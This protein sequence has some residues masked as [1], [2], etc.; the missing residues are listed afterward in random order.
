MRVAFATPYYL[1]ALKFGGPPQKIHAIARR[2]VEAG[3]NVNVLTFNH[4][5][6]RSA[7]RTE[8]DGV[9]VQ[10]LPWRGQGLRQLPEDRSHPTG[11]HSRR[12]ACAMASAFYTALV[13]M[14]S[15]AAKNAGI[16]VVQE[17]LGMYP[18]RG[19]NQLVKRLY[20]T[21]VTR[22]LVREAAA[23]IAASEAEATDL[24][25]FIP[26]AKVVQRRN[27]IDVEAF[28]QLP[29][30]DDLRRRW[31]I[32]T[33]EKV[34]LFVGRLSPIKNLE[35][36]VSAFALMG[37][38]VNGSRPAPKMLKERSK[39]PLGKSLQPQA[40]LVLVG[41]AEPAYEAAA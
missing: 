29:S 38:A 20:N 3:L 5:D 25:R 39:L 34:V 6:R 13:P 24:K 32:A 16:P 27:G 11:V 28:G 10:Y 15:R 14:V 18:P 4:E 30:S 41:P 37:E 9:A 2:L 21:F 12:G 36:L 22:R 26:G 1:P 23:V 7:A 31:H 33:D 17:P 19:R 35:Q 8:I 40:K